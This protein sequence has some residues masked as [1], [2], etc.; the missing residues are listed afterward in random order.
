[1]LIAVASS[2]NEQRNPAL[3]I[4][5]ISTPLNGAQARAFKTILG[6]IRR[7]TKFP[8][9]EGLCRPRERKDECFHA[10]FVTGLSG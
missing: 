5:E 2:R 9:K 4:V 6:K 3:E 7:G 8:D 10:S 1:M